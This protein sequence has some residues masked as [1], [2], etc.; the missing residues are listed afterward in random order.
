MGVRTE[1]SIMRLA[2]AALLGCV[3]QFAA[4]HAQESSDP[5]SA[6]SLSAPGAAPP[7]AP[8]PAEDGRYTYHR[9]QDSFVR[10]DSR[11]GQV[12]TCARGGA[13][14]VCQTAPDERAALEAEIGRLQTDNAALKKELLSRGLALPSGVKP[15]QAPPIP[16]VAEAPRPPNPV[17]GPPSAMESELK[18]L[19]GLVTDVW[20]KL[21]EMVAELQ[22]DMQRKS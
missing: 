13:G 11:T 7:S 3:V 19:T 15:E 12:A 20:R 21:V 17:P 22:K 18:R 8:A 9:I 6:P 4:A 1:E 16:P 14:W 10:L 5:S 2:I